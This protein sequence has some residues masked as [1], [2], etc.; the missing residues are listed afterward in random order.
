MSY[1]FNLCKGFVFLNY[2]YS[3]IMKIKQI[4]KNGYNTKGQYQNPHSFN[5]LFV[6]TGFKQKCDYYSSLIHY[7]KRIF[8]TTK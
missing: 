1:K 3:F 2:N 8:Y 7:F 5:M 6:H 4:T